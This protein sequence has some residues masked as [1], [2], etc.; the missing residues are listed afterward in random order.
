MKILIDARMYGLEN[1]GIGRYLINL[2]KELKNPSTTNATSLKNLNFVI[3][4]RN[5]YF[6]ELK[7]PGNWKKV[8][9]DLSH[10]SLAEQ[11]RLPGLINRE[12]PDLVHFPHLNIPFFWK[13]KFVV[14]V[15][16]LTMQ[17]QGVNATTLPLG[18][19]Y[20]KRVPFLL[21]LN[22]AV[23]E[24][25]KIIV[26][27]RAVKDEI[28]KNYKISLDKVKVINEGVSNFEASKKFPNKSLKSPYFLYVGNAYPHKNLET[29]LKA[30]MI[31][32][33]QSNTKTLFVV[34]G[35]RDVFKERLE[36]RIKKIGVE[37]YVKFVG[38][39]P[40]KDMANLYKRSVAFIYPSLSEGFGLQGLEALN[41]GT[42]L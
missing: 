26:P 2:I 19:Y 39:V 41:S 21:T 33:E 11:L 9:A 29:V 22:K 16:D 17:G 8:L 12:K 32:N 35:S 24:S 30:I 31:I 42:L 28:V 25:V 7:L 40:D 4:L 6:D 5:K 23:K 1:A 36:E 34:G 13:G 27:S 38:Y 3:L 15:H 14:T 10:Y 20:L 37:S 18:R